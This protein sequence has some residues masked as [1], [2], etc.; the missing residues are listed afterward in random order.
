MANTIQYLN[1]ASGETVPVSVLSD[2]LYINQD[3][4]LE[5][6]I[7]WINSNNIAPR[8]RIFV[9][10]PDETIN[11]EIPIEDILVG[12]S[13]NENYQNGQRR[14]LNF[15][16]Y[17]VHE[18][19][20]PSTDTLWA[21]T[22]LRLELGVELPDNTVIWF[23]KGIY[24]I[25]Q[26]NP[27]IDNGQAT[28]Q[29]TASDK[30]CLFEEKT[31][32]LEDTYEIEP[33]AD[34]ESVIKTIL[35][36]DMGNGY[37]LDSQPLIYHSS[38]KGKTTQVSISKSAGDTFGSILLD[39]A[40]QL[41]AEI[42]YNAMGLLTLVPTNEVTSDQDKALIFSYEFEKG[43]TSG[44]NFNYNMSEIIN[45][46]I[47]IGSSNNGGVHRAVAVNDDASSPL[48]YQKI[49]Y[50]TGPVVNDSN[51]TSDIL[52]EER[53]LYELRSHLILKTST[54]LSVLFN[55]LLDVNNLVA[56]TC[57]F[58]DLDHERFL[59]QSVSCNLD[60]SG[61]T[62][63]S[64]SNI[65][66][67]SRSK[68]TLTNATY[69][70]A[71]SSKVLSSLTIYKGLGVKEIY[72]KFNDND[73]YT[74]SRNTVR[75]MGDYRYSYSWYATPEDGYRVT[76]SCFSPSSPC[77]GNLANSATYYPEAVLDEYVP[78]IRQ[79]EGIDKIYYK[80][81]SAQDYTISEGEVIQTLSPGD[82]YTWYA[83]ATDEYVA[84]I[85]TCY[86][87][88]NP[89]TGTIIA[90]GIE[91][92]PTTTPKVFTP[93]ISE[94]GYSGSTNYTE[95]V[96]YNSNRYEVELWYGTNSADIDT[97][98]ST[99]VGPLSTAS[100]MAVNGTT[101]FCKFTVPGGDSSEVCTVS[102]LPAMRGYPGINEITILF[103]S[104]LSN[105]TLYTGGADNDINTLLSANARSPYVH[106][107][108][109]AESSHYYRLYKNK[110]IC[111]STLLATTVAG[112]STEYLP[113]TGTS[114]DDVSMT[115]FTWI[116]GKSTP[117]SN[118]CTLSSTKE[119]DI[120]WD[121]AIITFDPIMIPY[122]TTITSCDVTINYRTSF[123]QYDEFTMLSN[124]WDSGKDLYGYSAQSGYTTATIHANEDDM[125]IIS[126]MTSGDQFTIRFYPFGDDE[127]TQKLYLYCIK[128]DITYE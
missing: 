80:Y 22:R 107:N 111:S 34:I 91:Y 60:Y 12:G 100:F 14:S 115:K 39:L 125:D 19:Y 1:L 50:R 16:L 106:N 105:I 29:I 55:P 76:E 53:A 117:D 13:Y 70:A 17:N 8:Y 68:V 98:L 87:S 69:S 26:L 35:L 88:D 124:F 72:Y 30:F 126:Q 116:K 40:T 93:Q 66:N 113:L 51:I 46:V 47:V 77:V 99:N 90:D 52:A 49:G 32:T 42:F 9:L 62:N 82:Q 79:G 108:L 128:I 11:Y 112:Y 94:T 97:K 24:I 104:A 120:D 43:E 59:I 73:D 57:D 122:G 3:V 95:V 36:T 83:T 28:V 81:G 71:P 63:I 37:P 110:Y 54:N 23:Q 119:F 10:Y 84:D 86:S 102:S 33:G 67:L 6:L 114:G 31:G 20:T 38:F 48:C 92:I 15:S 64:I 58:F 74:V 25:T 27:S 44:I 103:E 7:F 123:G 89:C 101:Y 41:S 2:G 65:R 75:Q 121:P 127:T 96:I 18:K 45:R 118:F 4:N 56:I 61:T 21:G 85:S 78:I 5:Q 109:L